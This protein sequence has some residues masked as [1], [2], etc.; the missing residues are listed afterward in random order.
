VT[1]ALPL[2]SERVRRS[3]VIFPPSEVIKAGEFQA[4]VGEALVIYQKYR[5][6]L[7][8]GH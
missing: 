6:K 2:L 8:S 5:E 7:R 3:E 1:A 4:D